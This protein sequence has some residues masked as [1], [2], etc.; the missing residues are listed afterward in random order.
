M[1]ASKIPFG[2]SVFALVP[3][4]YRARLLKLRCGATMAADEVAGSR[5]LDFSIPEMPPA[6]S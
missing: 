4:K 5:K 6:V 2:R 1:D 3:D